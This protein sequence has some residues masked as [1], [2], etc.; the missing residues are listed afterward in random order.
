MRGTTKADGAASSNELGQNAKG[1][2]LIVRDIIQ[3]CKRN[4][5]LVHGRAKRFARSFREG[6]SVRDPADKIKS[7][8]YVVFGF[9]D[10]E[11]WI[12]HSPLNIGN[13]ELRRRGC[14]RSIDVNLHRNRQVVRIAEQGKHS[15]YL[16]G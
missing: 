4:D 10:E 11:A 7:D 5:I 3:F 14:L 12:L 1:Y 13:I 9:P 16:N 15:A 6:Q 8:R 2:F